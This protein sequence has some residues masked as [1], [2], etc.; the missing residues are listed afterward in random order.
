VLVVRRC[1]RLGS[2]FWMDPGPMLDAWRRVG[3]VCA[4]L[5]S[6]DKQDQKAGGVMA[7]TGMTGRHSGRSGQR[8]GE[9]RERATQ[10]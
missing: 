6:G 10:R 1:I 4:L 3:R 7:G 2:N 9:A 8:N 5:L